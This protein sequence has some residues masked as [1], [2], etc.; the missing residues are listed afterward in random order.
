MADVRRWMIGIGASLA[1]GLLAACGS[2]PPS[3]E[4]TRGVDAR[5]ADRDLLAGLAA[6]AKDKRYV[7]TYTLT[8]RTAP[9]VR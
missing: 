8:A 3:P 1:M 9:T 5:P 4:P 7:A 2:S 6:V